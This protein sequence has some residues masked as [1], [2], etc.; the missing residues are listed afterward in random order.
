MKFPNKTL[1]VKQL[2][3]K[4]FTLS[5]VEWKTRMSAG[6]VFTLMKEDFIWKEMF[7]FS[8]NHQG[9]KVRCSS[10]IWNILIKMLIVIFLQSEKRV[11]FYYYYFVMYCLHCR[12]NV[13]KKKKI[14]LIIK[15]FNVLFSFLIWDIWTF[16]QKYKKGELKSTKKLLTLFSIFHVDDVD[17]FLLNFLLFAKNI[18]T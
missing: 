15:K 3:Y 6:K 17:A 7:L 1:A 5:Q 14:Q 18:F 10:V 4:E 12:E 16:H 13:K 11:F 8:F 2:N 9:K